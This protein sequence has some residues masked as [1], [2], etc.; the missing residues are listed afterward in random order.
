[1]SRRIQQVKRQSIVV[2][3]TNFL[4]KHWIAII[5]L[6]VA[7]SGGVPGILSLVD[8]IDQKRV[9]SFDFFKVQPGTIDL[10]EEDIGET[11]GCF[12]ISGVIINA[13]ERPLY[14]KA[15]R[16]QIK[17]N[18][19]LNW[20]VASQIPDTLDGC[21]K[22]GSFFRYKNLRANDIFQLKIINAHEIYYGSL[23]FVCDLSV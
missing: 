20:P 23:F 18:N 1:M 14:P 13:G 19:V 5:T 8:H 11:K 21:L 9:V 6:S 17:S 22:D 3:K 15:Y 4:K 16:L 12:L 7:L 10:S 2:V